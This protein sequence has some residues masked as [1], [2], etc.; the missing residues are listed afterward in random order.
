M[1]AVIFILCYQFGDYEEDTYQSALLANEKLLP[2]QVIGQ[3]RLTPQM[4]EEHIKKWYADR[5]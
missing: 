1:Q 5:S 2:A 3:Y 4:W